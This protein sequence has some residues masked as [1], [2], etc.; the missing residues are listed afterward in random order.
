MNEDTIIRTMALP[1]C[2]EW[3]WHDDANVVVLSSSLDTAGRERALTEVAAHCRRRSLRVVND[4][5]MELLTARQQLAT[6]S[7]GWV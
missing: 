3:E 2:D 4:A 6:L 1:R 7:M 5:S